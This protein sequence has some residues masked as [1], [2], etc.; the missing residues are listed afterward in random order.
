[1]LVLAAG[2]DDV[3]ADLVFGLVEGVVLTRQ[4]KALPDDY[5]AAGADA[6]VRITGLVT[7]IDA[8]RAEG[9]LLL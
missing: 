6:G 5:P 9:G 4:S 7:D 3:A 1:V 8:V 2:G